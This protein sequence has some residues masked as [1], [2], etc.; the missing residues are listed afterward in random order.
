MREDLDVFALSVVEGVTFA[1][2]EV[3]LVYISV[4]GTAAGLSKLSD[5]SL[6]GIGE[7]FSAGSFASWDEAVYCAGELGGMQ[8]SS[9]D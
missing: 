5:R 3:C 6:A 1:A 9:I 4:V 8:S 2:V 7:D